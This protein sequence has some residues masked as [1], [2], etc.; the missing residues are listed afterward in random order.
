M[1]KKLIV[2]LAAL[3]AATAFAAVDA[4]K[5]SQAEL[6]AVKGIGPVI[7]T[8]IINERKKGEFKNWDD[9]VVR[10]KGVGDKNAVKLSEQGLTVN[11]ASFPGAPAKAETSTGSKAASATRTGAERAASATR[12]TAS[13]AASA[14]KGGAAVVKEDAK[15]QKDAVKQNAQDAK[16]KRAQKKAERAEKKA[17]KKAEKAAAA[18]APA[19]TAKK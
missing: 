9:M 12:T 14:V 2:A 8:V 11:G 10:V 17:E 15:E 5:A 19:S 18:S 1:F 7:S 16:D 3:I 6:E 13:K 4:N